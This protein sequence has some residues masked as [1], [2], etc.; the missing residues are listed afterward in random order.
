M[1]PQIIGAGT[2]PL[3]VA[4][5][6]QKAK[7]LMFS[8]ELPNSGIATP[9][10]SPLVPGKGKAPDL[11]AIT[12]WFNRQLVRQQQDIQK[13]VYAVRE[14][15]NGY[16]PKRLE[17]VRTYN[18]LVL[19]AHLTALMNQRKSALL[20]RK[21]TVTL[22]GKDITADFDEYWFYKFLGYAWEADAFGYSLIGLGDIVAGKV[23]DVKLL[24]RHLVSPDNNMYLPNPYSL[25]GI[26][27]DD[28]K[29]ENWY[30]L[31]TERN[32][33]GWLHKAGFHVLSKKFV[34]TSWDEYAMVFGVPIRVAKLDSSGQ[35][36]KDQITDD[37]YNMGP[38]GVLTLNK[39]D[40]FEL[41]GGGQSG[42]SSYQIFQEHIRSRNEE[43]SKLVVGQ[44]MTT[45]NGSSRSQSEVHERV[46]K[47]IQAQDMRWIKHVVNKQ[48]MPRLQKLG[49]ISGLAEFSWDQDELL[50][51]TEQKDVDDMILRNGYTIPSSY[52]VEKY[53]VPVEEGRQPAPTDPPGKPEPQSQGR[54]MG[55]SIQALTTT[56]HDHLPKHVRVFREAQAL[57]SVHPD[58]CGCSDATNKKVVGGPDIIFN[59]DYLES[60]LQ[61]F[62]NGKYL[63][64]K[65]PEDLYAKT[66]SYLFE[67]VVSGFGG[68]ALDYDWGTPNRQMLEALKKNIYI[69][70]GAKTYQQR[71]A[72]NSLLR[73]KEGRVKLWPEFKKDALQ[74]AKD[75]NVNYLQ[76]EYEAAVGQSR[77]A[78][79]WIDIEANKDIAPLLRY[80]T[81]G[82][83]NVREA[84]RKLDGIIRKVDDPFWDRY[85]PK[86]GWRCRCDVDQLEKDEGEITSLKHFGE[87][88]PKDQPRAFRFNPGKKKMVFSPQHP[89]FDV[90]PIDKN[91]AKQNFD[92]PIP[93]PEVPTIAGVQ[94]IG[95][96][97]SKA[98]EIEAPDF[99][100][101][102]RQALAAIDKIHGDGVIPNF[103]VTQD[104]PEEPGELGFFVLNRLEKKPVKINLTKGS[105]DG[106]NT[107][108]HEVGH[109][110]D[111]AAG[112]FVHYGSYIPGNP[113]RQ[114]I[115]DH[116]SETSPIINLVRFQLIFKRNGNEKALEAVEYLL[117]PTEIIARY[118]HQYILHKTGV[119]HQSKFFNSETEGTLGELTQWRS[120]EFERNIPNFESI[121]KKLNWQI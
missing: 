30:I 36:D 95:T 74:L 41:H 103:P 38:A 17:L 87:L 85:M 23:T 24:E 116:L 43:L 52:F 110:I 57:Y 73:T 94:P 49:V 59:D 80:S 91:W 65:L 112:D 8:P 115:F 56:T 1:D 60:V 117:D 78:A 3:W 121:L 22:G 11:T 4:L 28:P 20:S 46:A 105:T 50:S 10:T 83:A 13:L 51:L 14:A 77:M 53:G 107:F 113:M 39:E 58:G 68:Q 67:G 45:D 62:F 120:E 79:R 119:N 31:V 106:Y 81:V 102:I 5:A 118:Y 18:D 26:K 100:Q 12:S 40:E 44:T 76:A 61:E 27:L 101:D 9:E 48:L 75:Y 82:D 16:V 92:L 71:K 70:S 108:L 33:L 35:A 42:A 66:A 2:K 93:E 7:N 90:E 97:V 69:F 114:F 6:E 54:A 98:V 19:D 29:L 86:N 32:N 15:E 34:F 64:G 63:P 72:Y 37:L 84:H 55:Q 89:Y 21:F 96:P 88:G 104:P 99:Q 25:S 109:L 111:A 47:N